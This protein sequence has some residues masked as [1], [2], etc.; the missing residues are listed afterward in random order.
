MSFPTLLTPRL[1]LRELVPADADALLAIHGDPEVMR[2]FGAEPLQSHQQALQLIEVFAEWR[3]QPAPGTRWAITE[4]E[5]GRL[6]GT[7]GLFKWNRSWR[8]CTLGY[9][10]ARSAWGLG[11]MREAL[12][13]VLDYGFDTMALHRVQA[14]IHPDN[15]ASSKLVEHL[16][17]RLEG[18][19]R[20]QGYW[21]GRFHDLNC[22]SL[23]ASEWPAQGTACS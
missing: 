7:C 9:E 22:Y 21:G 3:R 15:L 18:M 6:L 4:R 17:F 11:L 13:T 16:G 19:H 8:N 12:V 23:L 20:E 10:L 5:G 14:E 2:W 1:R